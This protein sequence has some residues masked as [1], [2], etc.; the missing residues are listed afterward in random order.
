VNGMPKR[1][2]IEVE[3]EGSPRACTAGVQAH[4]DR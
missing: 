3:H 1:F 2:L 4:L